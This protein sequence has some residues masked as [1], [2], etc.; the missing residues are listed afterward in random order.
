MTN[1]S[2]IKEVGS[3]YKWLDSRIQKSIPDD[4]CTGCGECC[5]FEKYGHR[6]YISNLELLYLKSFIPNLP[7]VVN[8]RCPFME[9]NK[10]TVRDY[11]FAACR[12]FFCKAD[13]IFQ[14]DLS[15][16]FIK[17]IKILSKTYKVEYRYG[18]LSSMFLK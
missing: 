2:L 8:G 12:I 6:I 5:E 13:A 7:A 4:I 9:G 11:R 16:E 3:L 17:K 14:Q 10:C 15:E 1:S 18:N